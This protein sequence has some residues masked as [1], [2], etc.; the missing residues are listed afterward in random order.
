MVSSKEIQSPDPDGVVYVLCIYDSI[1]FEW[2]FLEMK[3]AFLWLYRSTGELSLEDAIALAWMK[4]L[5]VE[6]KKRLGMLRDLYIG[7]YDG[8]LIPKGTNLGKL[9]RSVCMEN[10]SELIMDAKLKR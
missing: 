5:A 2:S 9:Y 1:K 4:P 3:E 6:E 7:Q 8:K 10:F